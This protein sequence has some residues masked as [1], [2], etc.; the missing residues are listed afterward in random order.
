VEKKFLTGTEEWLRGWERG[1]SGE[2][3]RTGREVRRGPAGRDNVIVIVSPDAVRRSG[4]Y[5]GLF[6]FL[7]SGKGAIGDSHAD[8]QLRDKIRQ[9][10]ES[11]RKTD[12]PGVISK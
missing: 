4:L 3:G 10:A 5:P 2:L 7:P 9:I 8:F 11:S 6:S 1:L 12:F